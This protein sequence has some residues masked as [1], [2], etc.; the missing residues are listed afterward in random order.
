MAGGSWEYVVCVLWSR[1]GSVWMKE[2]GRVR[3]WWS[4]LGPCLLGNKFGIGLGWSSKKELSETIPFVHIPLFRVGL[5]TFTFF[6]DKV[7]EC[8]GI[9]LRL[10]FHW[11]RL[12]VLG[13]PHLHKEPF[14]KVEHVISP[15]I[16]WHSTGR[17]WVELPRA[18]GEEEAPLRKES[19]AFWHKKEKL[20]DYNLISKVQQE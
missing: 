5:Y 4:L 13:I 18:G 17:V 20:I 8:E 6:S 2:W 14:Q 15:G 12:K 16:K 11:L 3:K 9:F 7:R 19:L 1:C 10:R